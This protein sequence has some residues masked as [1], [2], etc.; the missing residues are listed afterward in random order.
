MKVIVCLDYSF[1]IVKKNKWWEIIGRF[2][3]FSIK[4]DVYMMKFI[5]EFY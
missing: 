3:W 4:V 1:I 2:D 5:L